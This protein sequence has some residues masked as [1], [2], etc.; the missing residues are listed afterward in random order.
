MHS[1][2]KLREDAR[3]EVVRGILGHAN[4]D[5]TQNVY[6]KSWWDRG[7]EAP[8]WPRT[9]F[10]LGVA[11]ARFFTP[12]RLSPR[13]NVLDF[14]QPLFFLL[15]DLQLAG[16]FRVVVRL[17][18]VWSNNLA[19]PVRGGACGFNTGVGRILAPLRGL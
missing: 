19:I 2:Y 17:F 4:I 7:F 8:T 1:S 18:V 6:G 10:Q 14:V 9:R 12:N 3:P 16:F 15:L 13:D 11:H 5:V